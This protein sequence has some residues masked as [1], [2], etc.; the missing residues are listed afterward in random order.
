MILFIS[1]GASPMLC[2]QHLLLLELLLL[3]GQTGFDVEDVLVDI[4]Y[5][6]DHTTKRKSTLAQYTEFC[7]QE[8]GKILKHVSTRWL[9]LEKSIIHVLV[10][11]ISLKSYFLSFL[12][13]L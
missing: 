11:Y 9:S 8:Y 12:I 4:H 10:Q 2:T 7:D 3:L 1:V 5:W 6:F 13:K